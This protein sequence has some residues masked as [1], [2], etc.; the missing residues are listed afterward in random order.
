MVNENPPP[1]NFTAECRENNWTRIHFILTAF[2]FSFFIK[3][4]LKCKGIKKKT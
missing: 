2:F 4:S 3:L 1:I